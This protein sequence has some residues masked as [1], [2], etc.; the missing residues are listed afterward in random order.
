MTTPDTRPM[1][2]SDLNPDT[3][4]AAAAPAVEVAVPAEAGASAPES[5][6]YFLAKR[7]NAVM[8]DSIATK[9]GFDP[10]MEVVPL[11]AT[12]G[13]AIND[14][15][16]RM[17]QISLKGEEKWANALT[18]G[19]DMGFNSGEYEPALSDPSALWTTAP[20]NEAGEKL[21]GHSL[22]L[23]AG[24]GKNLKGDRAVLTVLSHMGKGTLFRGPLWNTGIW[25]TVKAPSEGRLIE[26]ARQIVDAKISLGRVTYGV[27]FSNHMVYTAELF[28]NMLRE[29]EY[30]T[31][32]SEKVKLDEIISVQ[33]LMSIVWALTCAIYPNGYNYERACV[34][35]PEKCN[36]VVEDR[37]NVKRMQVVN[38]NA[39]CAD[40]LRHMSNMRN[41]SV[42]LEEIQ[43]YQ[44]LFSHTHGVSRELTSRNGKK[45]TVELKVPTMAEF[46]NVGHRWVE[47]ISSMVINALGADAGIGARNQ[48]MADL[49]N[50]TSSRQHLH[51]VKSITVDTD[52][53]NDTEALE[54]VF[55][56]V[57]S[58]DKDLREQF[59]KH[60]LDF[61]N[62]TMTT[63]IAIPN[64]TCPACKGV[65]HMT[66]GAAE[67][68]D[69]PAYIP[70]DPFSTFF[71]LQFQRV[72]LIRERD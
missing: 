14:A 46:I 33:D 57:I 69:V 1:D 55:E 22:T 54:K 38:Q 9:E 20:T 32:A 62:K 19:Q 60:V 7:Q 25:L 17:G 16:A 28:M 42:T 70:V 23:D 48:Y 10:G 11:P 59:A 40:Q 26:Y 61:T 39:L 5:V 35:N 15:I 56:N 2:P 27:S 50:A 37:I 64:Y 41:R 49:A 52:V 63:V 43:K 3:P 51:W 47:G 58:V 34:S 6:K 71:D 68:E 18:R 36:H 67:G 13:A 72:S 29:C 8:P 31:T 66:E 65:Q 45:L 21:T 4:A 53:I 24:S 12:F 30:T 44:S